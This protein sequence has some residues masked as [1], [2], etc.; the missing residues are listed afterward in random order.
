MK[1]N[2]KEKISAALAETWDFSEGF[3]GIPENV[4]LTQ[5]IGCASNSGN[6]AKKSLKKSSSDAS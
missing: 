6:K 5:N 4:S 1:K 2:R 3:G